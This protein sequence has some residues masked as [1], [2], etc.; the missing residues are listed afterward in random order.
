[1]QVKFQTFVQSSADFTLIY[2]V[3]Y[4]LKPQYDTFKELHYFPVMLFIHTR[5]AWHMFGSWDG[6]NFTWGNV[7]F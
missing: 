5:S 6:F 3:K 7:S 2:N 1:M 4:C